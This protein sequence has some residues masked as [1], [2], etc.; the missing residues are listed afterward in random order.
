MEGISVPQNIHDIRVVGCP[1]VQFYAMLGYVPIPT[2]WQNNKGQYFYDHD[3]AY[4]YA[5]GSRNEI[6]NNP[7]NEIYLD[8]SGLDNG[9]YIIELSSANKTWLNKV[10]KE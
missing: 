2:S 4:M 6:L 10:I 3:R 7:N 8:L 1:N 9:L 5:H